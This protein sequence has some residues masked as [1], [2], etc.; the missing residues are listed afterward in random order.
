MS[1]HSSIPGLTSKPPPTRE[2]IPRL[3][4]TKTTIRPPSIYDKADINFREIRP[5][6]QTIE[7]TCY[8]NGLLHTATDAKGQV[9]NYN[10]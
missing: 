7:Y 10:Q 1:E 8:A 9:T 3:S 4:R 2:V 6:G 5:T